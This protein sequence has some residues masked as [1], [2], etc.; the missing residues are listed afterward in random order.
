MSRTDGWLKGLRLKV[1]IFL[2]PYRY[3]IS[4]SQAEVEHSEL[5]DVPGTETLC[6]AMQRN[7]F[8]CTKDSENAFPMQ[9]AVF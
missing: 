2:I 3:P 6:L 8:L 7:A 9:Y 5:L 4:Y 1:R